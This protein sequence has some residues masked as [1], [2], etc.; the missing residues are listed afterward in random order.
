MHS[1]HRTGRAALAVLFVTLA[2][3]AALPILPDTVETYRQSFNT[4]ATVDSSEFSTLPEGWSVNEAGT[5]ANTRLSASNGGSNSGNTYSYGLAGDS[6]RALG[7]LASGSVTPI[8]I[9]LRLVNGTGKAVD[10]VSVRFLAE[11]WRLGAG[12]VDSL[13]F[14]WSVNSGA[15][16]ADTAL[17]VRKDLTGTDLANP[18]ANE[19]VLIREAVIPASLAAG[20]TLVLTWTDNNAIGNDEGWGI[21]DVSVRLAHFGAGAVVVPP[22]PPAV[23]YKAIHAIQ[24]ASSS[25]PYLDSTVN[26]TGIVTGAFQAPGQLGGF[27]VQTPDAEA[28][29]DSMTSE[30]ILIYTGTSNPVVAVGDSVTV[31]GKVAEY[32]GLTEITSPVVTVVAS[33]KVLPAAIALALPFDSLQAPERVEGMRVSLAQTL[34]VTGNYGLGRYGEFVVA[35]RRVLAATQVVRP[36]APA[37]AA[38]KAD[39]LARLVVSDASTLQNPASVPFPTGGLSAA[40]PLRTGDKVSGLEGILDYQFG[41]WTLQPTKS[42]VF[43][44]ANARTPAP[45]SGTGK[46]KVASFN[47]LNYFTTLGAGT[48]CGPQGALGCRGASDSS[49]FRR[50]KSKILSA[51]KALDADIVGLM[52]IENHPTDSALTDLVK[53]LNDSTVAGRWS[54]IQTGALGG[55]AIKVALIYRADRVGLSGAYAT[56]T[57][58]TDASFADTKHRVPVAQ[59]F[60]DLGSGR[61]FTVVVNHLKSKSSACDG[62]PDLGDGQ[63]NC[64][65]TRTNGARALAAWVK[66]LPTGTTSPDALLLGDFNAYAKEDAA[67]LLVDSGFVNLGVRDEGDS[68]YSY[69]YGN[70]FGTLDHAFATAELAKRAKASHWAINADEP[71]VLGYNQEYKSAAQIESFFAP[72]PYGSSDHDPILVTL[73]LAQ[74]TALEESQR[75]SVLVRRNG[76][77]LFLVAPG[78]AGR[79]ELRNLDGNLVQSGSL[80]PSGVTALSAGGA[81]IKIVRLRI[82]GETASRT[83]AVTVP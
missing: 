61:S 1:I 19:Q 54:A 38:L 25:S 15:E 72:D 5:K 33:G 31:S 67:M 36:G 56:L 11:Q 65:G 75:S 44:A 8:R 64:S 29:G 34:T 52:E 39:S 10:S 42:P 41:L 74:T 83:F 68:S 55:D 60:K 43:V 12:T 69:Q 49:E 73:D 78:A 81:G 13:A 37:I 3:Q 9:Q 17:T 4:L 82:D 50:Q 48:A 20:D 77:G 2:S 80:Q 24:G 53:G 47:V 66:G 71:V 58:S 18:T 46:L 57:S 63:G 62:D 35:P 23:V 45:P 6:D 7:S 79:F 22:P 21:D 28:D 14:T 76:Q 70:A 32:K 16:T 59:T 27:F 26:L 51:L 40:N 30:G